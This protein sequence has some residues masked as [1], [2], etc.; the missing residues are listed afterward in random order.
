MK[1]ELLLL[2]AVLLF[3]GSCKKDNSVQPAGQNQIS[4]LARESEGS[5]D[6]NSDG[7]P[8]SRAFHGSI[9]YQLS[10]TDFLTCNCG[11]LSSAG[12]YTGSGT[13]SHLGITTSNIKPCFAPIFS[14]NNVVGLYTGSECASFVAANNDVVYLNTHPYN[15]MF[16]NTGASGSVTIDIIG[17]TGRFNNASGSFTATVTLNATHTTGALDNISGTITY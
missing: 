6:D 12:T 11:N 4:T 10:A 8:H 5:D 9:T 3:I 1:K 15:L 7:N 13:L 2:A 16:T 17:G 14:G